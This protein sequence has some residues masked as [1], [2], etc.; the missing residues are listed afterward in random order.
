VKKGQVVAQI[1]P[2]LFEGAVLQAKG[3]LANAQAN[4]ASARAN[5][6]KAKAGEIQPRRTTIVRLAWP[7]NQ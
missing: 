7:K 5:L 1:D 4:V 6:E 3:D 2:A